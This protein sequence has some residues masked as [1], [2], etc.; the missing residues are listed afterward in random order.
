[1]TKKIFFS[2]LFSV[3]MSAASLSAVAAVAAD[4]RPGEAPL[5]G[6]ATTEIMENCDDCH[7]SSTEA[8][9]YARTNKGETDAER[10]ATILGKGAPASN[11]RRGDTKEGNN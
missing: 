4:A 7:A 11:D 6:R 3:L 8:D 1:M 5:K 9:R 2:S 10:V